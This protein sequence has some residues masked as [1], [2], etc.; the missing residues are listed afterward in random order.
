MASPVRV[1]SRDER[2]RHHVAVLRNL[3]RGDDPRRQRG[4]E[5]A[6]R[7]AVQAAML[8]AVLGQEARQLVELACAFVVER[9]LQRAGPTILRRGRDSLAQRGEERL[10]GG[11]ASRAQRSQ[12]GTVAF[13]VRR[14]DAGRRLRGAPTGGAWIENA[15]LGTPSR[16]LEGHRTAYDSGP[17]DKNP[18]GAIL[19]GA[20][21]RRR[22]VRAIG[23]E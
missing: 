19:V 12:P 5:R 21:C 2:V 7:R 14:E 18:H 10:V 8:D 4:L 11:H 3:Q 13:D 20:D 9:R 16:A 6:G 1:S 15:D 23:G 17:D 22:L